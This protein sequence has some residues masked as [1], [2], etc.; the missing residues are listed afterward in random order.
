MNFWTE[1]ITDLT[2]LFGL[3]WV[4]DVATNAATNTAN[5]LVVELG[6]DY[7]ANTIDQLVLR[8]IYIARII[9]FANWI[10]HNVDVYF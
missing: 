5:W 4:K 3:D 6:L 2:F 1:V 9:T 8:I 10:G 7:I